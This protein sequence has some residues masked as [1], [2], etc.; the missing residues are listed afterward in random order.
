MNVPRLLPFR[1]LF[2]VGLVVGLYACIDSFTPKSTLNT[3]LLVIEGIITDQPVTQAISLSRSR[4]NA[5]SNTSRPVTGATVQIIVNGTTAINLR[6]SRPGR[7]AFPGTFRGKVGDSYQLRFT[8][9]DGS[10][11]ESTVETM[12]AV[13]PIQNVYDQFEPNGPSI[14]YDGQPSPCNNIYLDFQDPANERNFYLWRWTLYEKQDWCAT[15]QQGRY[16]ITG[17]DSNLVGACIADP[18]LSYYNFYDYTCRTDCW[19]LFYSKQINVFSDIYTN[20]NTQI[21]R[22]IAQIPVFAQVPALVDVEQL[23]LTANAYRYYKLFADQAQ[24]TGTLADSPPAPTV[25]N[26]RNLNDANENVVGYFTASAVSINH[27]WLDRK[28]TKLDSYKGLFY[29]QNGRV[30]NVELPPDGSS[31]FGQGVPS[32]LCIPSATR[33]NQKPVGWH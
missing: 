17:T 31:V 1:L 10:S 3:D 29:A 6:E 14:R 9:A 21:G 4:S 11:Y 27:Y 22:L 25:G 7:Y 28:N 13:A 24:N 8:T 32:A 15:C 12:I 5:D 18:K 2:V 26:V 20:G 16:R 19:D 33:T 23:S 30:P